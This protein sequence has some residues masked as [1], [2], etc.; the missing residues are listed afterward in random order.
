[1]I[2]GFGSCFNNDIGNMIRGFCYLVV[3]T[4]LEFSFILHLGNFSNADLINTLKTLVAE[5]WHFHYLK[6]QVSVIKDY[7]VS[8]I[9]KHPF[10]F[11]FNGNTAILI[12][13][14][15]CFLEGV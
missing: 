2:E 14:F 13:C 12:V 9:Y 4:I 1:M 11:A 7:S 15:K 5:D 6:L 10:S 8:L 3:L